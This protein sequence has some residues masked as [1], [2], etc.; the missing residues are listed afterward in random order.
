MQVCIDAYRDIFVKNSFLDGNIRTYTDNA[1]VFGDGYASFFDAD[2]L[3][4]GSFVY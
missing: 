4:D 2:D 1:A 3:A